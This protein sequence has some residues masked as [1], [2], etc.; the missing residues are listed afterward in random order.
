VT[1]NNDI[2]FSLSFQRK[3]AN[4]DEKILFL[5]LAVWRNYRS[6]WV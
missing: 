3:F 6:R 1:M 4:D 5:H 2:V